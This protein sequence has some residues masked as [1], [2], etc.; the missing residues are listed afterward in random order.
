MTSQHRRYVQDILYDVFPYLDPDL[1][2]DVEASGAR[3]A[4]L[5]SAITSRD[6]EG[7]ALDILWRSLPS[8]RPLALLLCTLGIADDQSPPLGHVP[9]WVYVR[10]PSL[11]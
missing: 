4:L 3:R 1:Y 9:P 10:K 6:F 7:P 2:V 5:A 8:P 11:S